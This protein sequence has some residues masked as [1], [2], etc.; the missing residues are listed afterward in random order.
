MPSAGQY[1]SAYSSCAG[2]LGDIQLF[3]NT[4]APG[5][6]LWCT[7]NCG[8]PDVALPSSTHG[9]FFLNFLNTGKAE[10]TI[11]SETTFDLYSVSEG[12]LDKFVHD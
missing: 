6:L 2:K 8:N 7:T 9:V 12:C 10:A 4:P 5:E 1:Y 11:T 3:P